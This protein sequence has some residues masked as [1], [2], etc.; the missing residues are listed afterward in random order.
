M[1]FG[2]FKITIYSSNCWTVF[3]NE[4][5]ISLPNNTLL[6]Y[7]DEKVD[8]CSK[9]YDLLTNANQCSLCIGNPDVKFNEIRDR[10][11]GKFVDRLGKLFCK[12]KQYFI[13]KFNVKLSCL[14][15]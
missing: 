13:N 7:T 12:H 11:K 10:R 1:C 8:T 2:L 6:E 15:L 14:S 5:K 3:I 9:V 4:H